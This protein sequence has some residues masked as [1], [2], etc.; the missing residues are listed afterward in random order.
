MARVRRLTD[1][2]RRV[3]AEKIM[4][5]GNLV[6]VGLAITQVFSGVP[7]TLVRVI[8]GACALAGAYWF[9]IRLMKGGD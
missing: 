4:D 9:A 6:F 5:W 7:L 8:V 3:F 1:G 2:E